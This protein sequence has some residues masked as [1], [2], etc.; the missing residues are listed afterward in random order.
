MCF[1]KKK[2]DNASELTNLNKCL[3]SR[4][5]S[6]S[7]Y[8][9]KYCF[10]HSCVHKISFLPIDS[11][12]A[13]LEWQADGAG[14]VCLCVALVVHSVLWLT[15]GNGPRSRWV[16]IV[17][18][19]RRPSKCTPSTE[20]S[21]TSTTES[22]RRYFMSTSCRM[23]RSKHWSWAKDLLS[24][25]AEMSCYER[26]YYKGIYCTCHFILRQRRFN[27]KKK[28]VPPRYSTIRNML[29]MFLTEFNWI[30]TPSPDYVGSPGWRRTRKPMVYRVSRYTR[31]PHR[32]ITRSFKIV[33]YLMS[34]TSYV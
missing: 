20:T 13:P 3:H 33:I 4:S 11:D 18:D 6:R 29:M 26:M 1:S 32:N 28:K 7:M 12:L 30:A 10:Y 27:L 9:L 34:I 14:L 19:W 21:T 16:S 23:Y 2:I 24:F 15:G 22:T 17:R 5:D 31:S 8:N 25:N